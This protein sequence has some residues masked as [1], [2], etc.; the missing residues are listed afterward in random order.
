MASGSNS[1]VL[2]NENGGKFNLVVSFNENSTS[3][4]N[5]TSNITCTAKL[6]KNNARF[7]VNNAGVLKVYWHDNRS[8]TDTEWAS[9]AVTELGYNTTERTATATKNVTHKD[10]GTLSGY[11]KATW[12]RNSS[13]G[14]YAPPSGN[15]STS[16]TTLTTIPRASAPTLANSTFNIG[17]TITINTN[18][19]SSTFTHT[20]T[21]TYGSTTTTIGTNV[22]ASL[23]YNTGNIASG[24]YAVI[25]NATSL[26]GTITCTT[27]SGS[28]NVGSKTCSFTAKAVANNA[29]PTFSNFTFADTNSTTT[30]ITGNNQVMISG[31]STLAATITSANKAT[32]RY[33][34]TMKKYTFAVAGLSAEQTYTT[35]DI[36]KSMGSPGVAASELPSG[37]RDFV[38]TAIDSRGYSTAVTKKVTIV[39]YSAPAI[40]AT[41]KRAN[42]FE[43]TT[44]VNISGTFSRIEVG[45]TAKNTVNAT[46]GVQYRYKPQNSTTWTI[47]WTNKA[48]TID[49]ATGKVTVAAF[50]HDLDNQTAYD[51]QFRITDRLQT[52]TASIVVAVGQ[53]TFWIG[54]DGRVA[55]GGMPTW[56]MQS[57]NSGQLEV[58]G[59]AYAN[60]SR[61]I[62]RNFSAYTS[63]CGGTSGS[64]T[65]R[66]F[67]LGH[68][69]FTAHSQGKMVWLRVLI[70]I[71]NNGNNNQQAFLDLF[72]QL[73]WTGSNGGRAGWSSVYNPCFTGSSASTVQPKII[74][75]NNPLEYDIWLHFKSNNYCTTST[76]LMPIGQSDNNWQTAWTPNTS[77]DWTSTEPS[78]TACACSFQQVVPWA[79]GQKGMWSQFYWSGSALS[80]RTETVYTKKGTELTIYIENGGG[81]AQIIGGGS[82]IKLA[83]QYVSTRHSTSVNANY[84]VQGLASG[85]SI[86]T[87][88]ISALVNNGSAGVGQWTATASTGSNCYGDL[89]STTGGSR[90]SSEISFTAM[91][92]ADTNYWTLRGN[93]SS[94]GVATSMDFECRCTAYN[95]NY[96]PTAFQ[97]GIS[98]SNVANFWNML[99]VFEA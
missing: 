70:G 52:T 1:T 13:Y 65:D 42:G 59:N 9:L 32:A 24:L 90:S 8:N 93:A 87:R 53:P 35:S 29:K 7:D 63:F 2:T 47:D 80:N 72:G 41:A 33:S 4:E 17:D 95:A 83:R 54:A 75:T 56:T 92:Q 28:T 67:K 88:Y 11:A 12:T 64:T 16:N 5:N 62:E 34:A 44:T 36:T 74:V 98:T 60:G 40:N 30:A 71:G 43:N 82:G 99:E 73:G 45:G 69:K 6:T 68:L 57:G 66:W 97:R 23:S 10:D 38:V 51:F 39:P 77:A 37:T 81:I 85:S 49:T 78:G 48:A 86:Y 22:G 31:K 50:T 18:R 46:S 21:M 79:S 14:H 25:P 91:R 96:V 89:A 76:M 94:S 55:V 20:I 19:A 61:L 27:Y 26:T 58:R 15:V 84:G 3:T